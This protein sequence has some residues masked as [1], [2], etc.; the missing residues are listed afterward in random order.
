MRYA[1][2]TPLRKAT[3]YEPR[4]AILGIWGDTWLTRGKHSIYVA[5]RGSDAFCHVK[6]ALS[7]VLTCLLRGGNYRIPPIVLRNYVALRDNT[8]QLS[9]GPNPPYLQVRAVYLQKRGQNLGIRTWWV[10]P[11]YGFGSTQTLR[12]TFSARGTF[13]AFGLRSGYGFTPSTGDARAL[14][15]ANERTTHWLR[16]SFKFF[17][18]SLALRTAHLARAC[19]ARDKCVVRAYS[20]LPQFNCPMSTQNSRGPYRVST[21]SALTTHVVRTDFCSIYK[22]RADG[23][24]PTYH[25]YIVP[26]KGQWFKF[27]GLMYGWYFISSLLS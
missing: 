16:E 22:S 18:R 21:C 24:V 5:V 9:P 7:T 6:S 10:P 8:L 14:Y 26:R 2:V 1:V 19:C 17:P 23:R 11:Q 12:S 15:T 3:L 25:H 27:V 4:M 13:A 20:A